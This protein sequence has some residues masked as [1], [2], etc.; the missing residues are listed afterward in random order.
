MNVMQNKRSKGNDRKSLRSTFQQLYLFST[1][2]FIWRNTV[3]W[4]VKKKKH[5][6]VSEP[7]YPVF[8]TLCLLL[9]VFL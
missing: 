2:N 3:C 4:T 6:P 7:E 1:S 5:S 8:E 9:L